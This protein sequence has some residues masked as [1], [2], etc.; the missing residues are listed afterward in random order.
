[1]KQ[2]AANINNNNHHQFYCTK[3]EENKMNAVISA[4]GTSQKPM[5]YAIGSH[6]SRQEAL[7]SQKGRA[8]FISA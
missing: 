5:A 1:M 8:C 4:N 7:L 6:N 2:L 3:Y